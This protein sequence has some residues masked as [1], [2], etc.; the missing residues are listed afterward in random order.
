MTLVTIRK[1]ISSFLL[2]LMLD[3]PLTHLLNQHLLSS[4]TKLKGNLR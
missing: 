2:E 3:L 1:R 4:N